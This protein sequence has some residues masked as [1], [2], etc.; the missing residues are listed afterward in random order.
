MTIAIW[1]GGHP[2]CRL[3]QQDFSPR[4]VPNRALT[5]IVGT[6]RLFFALADTP[7]TAGRVERSAFQSI[8]RRTAAQPKTRAILTLHD[9]D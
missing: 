2:W 5:P 6:M 9:A 7:L 3:G 1:V 8:D 4:L